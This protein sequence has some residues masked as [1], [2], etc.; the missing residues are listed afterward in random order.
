MPAERVGEDP[1]EQHAD[2]AAAGR[3]EAEDTHRLRPLGRLGEQAHH[4]RQG[5]SG[6]DRPA[7]SLHRPRPHEEPLRGCETA[8]ERGDGE[9]A[10]PGNEQATVAEEVTQP[11]A[12]QE[13]AAV[14]EEVPVDDP[15]QGRLGELQVRPDGRQR[16]AHDR[17]VEHD[18]QACQAKDVEGKPAPAGVGDLTHGFGL[19]GLDGSCRLDLAVPRNS[20]V[21]CGG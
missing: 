21:G 1:A 4:Q 7:E 17:D 13:E 15:G 5:H 14:G 10:D 20:S 16:D 18:H 11:A 8:R 3:D 2:A 19:L 12:E 6:R 9:E